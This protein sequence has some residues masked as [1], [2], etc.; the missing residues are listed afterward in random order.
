MYSTSHPAPIADQTKVWDLK[1][2]HEFRFEVDFNNAVVLRLKS[3]TA[4]IFGAELGSGAEYRFT[5]QKAAVFTWHGCSL[6]IQGQC[7]V[8][9]VA[10]ETPMASYINLHTALQSRRVAAAA[11]AATTAMTAPPATDR[12]GQATV[13]PGT[14]G[15]VVMLI[16]PVDAGK[17]S[18]AKLLL[19]YA[20]RQGQHPMFINLD[21]AEGSVLMPG[22]VSAAPAMHILD[23]E[24][25]FDALGLDKTAGDVSTPLCYHYGFPSTTDNP[26]LYGLLAAKL[27]ETVRARL[28]RNH[29]TRPA[30]CIIDT[31]GVIDAAAGYEL[32]QQ[33]IADF[34]VD[35]VVVLGHERLYSDMCRLY[36]NSATVKVVKLAKS[37]GVVNRDKDFLRHAQLRTI[38]RYFYGSSYSE[39]SPFSTIAWYQNLKI[40]RV[41]DSI[42]PSSALPIGIDRKVSETQI[43]PMEPG[44]VLIHS[45]LTVSS[46]DA[47][48]DEDKLLESPAAGFVYVS[49]VDENKKSKKLT[50]LSPSPGRLPRKYLLLSSFKWMEM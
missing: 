2:E 13:A 5:G 43:V 41:E 25:G 31:G 19:N 50:L 20:V 15:P 23:P 38:R 36:G 10:D 32:I 4:E 40:Y 22:T 29:Q 11:A 35:L 14:T 48:E 30:G 46:L 49:S 21:P 3:G 33:S 1:P 16:G 28:A 44:P 17:T 9:Y 47:T 37:G 24:D 7:N 39:Y 34:H 12:E 6:E 45:I 18:L 26:K 42:A 8:A 27:A